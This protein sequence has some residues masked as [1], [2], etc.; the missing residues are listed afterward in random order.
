MITMITPEAYLLTGKKA[1]VTG[2]GQGIG[3][4]IVEALTNLGAHVAVAEI[5]EM[6]REQT[7]A[8]AQARGQKAIGVSVD[9][10]SQASVEA[11][12]QKV[13]KEFGQVDL[14]ANNVGGTA[15]VGPRPIYATTEEQW[16]A[17]YVM[18]AKSVYLV[19]R[20]VANQMIKQGKGGA[21]VSIAS[22]GGMWGHEN[23][24]LYGSMKAGLINLS[25]SLNGELG[26]YG[27]RVN[28]VSPGSIITPL[29]TKSNALRPD[30]IDE[31]IKMTPL[32]RKG[33]PANIAGAVAF[34]LSPAAEFI[35]GQ[36]ILVDGGRGF[37]G[38]CPVP[39]Y[40]EGASA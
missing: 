7:V 37:L 24:A 25:Q 12:V 28:S 13:V 34:L 30:Y 39:K 29:S 26:R 22:I 31:T 33:L 20:A 8:E 38:R 4:G 5:N 10:R 18:N 27:I 35:S 17:I 36:N 40:V 23:L 15:G 6:T 21:I 16:E 2:G 9:V 14:L 1:I 32:G 11:M 3:K 19:T